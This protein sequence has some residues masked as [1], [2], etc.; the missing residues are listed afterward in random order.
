MPTLDEIVEGDQAFPLTNV[1]KLQ[2]WLPWLRMFRGF[3]IAIDYQKVLVSLL[4]VCL[5]WLGI[6]LL[7]NFLLKDSE[8]FESRIPQIFTLTVDQDFSEVWGVSV[9]S[10]R[11]LT[12]SSP[13]HS[14]QRIQ[15]EADSILW[16]FERISASFLE[17]ANYQ[18]FRIWSH[19]WLQVLWGLVVAAVF[20][21]TVSRMAARELTGHSRS[22]IRDAR[23][24]CQISLTAFLAPVIALCGLSGLWVMGWVAGLL[25]RVPVLGEILLGLCWIVI[26]VLGLLMALV[27]L[28]LM[29]GWP[30]M[31]CSTAVERNDSFDALSRSL[32][33]LLNRPWYSAFLL[34]IMWGYGT[35]VLFFVTFLTRLSLLLGLSAVSA[36]HGSEVPGSGLPSLGQLQSLGR[37]VVT[38]EVAGDMI[39]LWISVVALVPAA[40]AFSFFWTS[41][42][43]AYFLL[44]RRE[45]G[46]PLHE[47]DLSDSP[48]RSKSVL[49]IVGI[50]AAENRERERERSDDS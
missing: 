13:S 4:A 10:L 6:V 27:L 29:L 24:A 16:P 22:V 21:G 48:S 17:L 50:P 9:P 31:C 8:R 23:F 7:E 34:I 15:T 30:L 35:V 14:L 12:V 42:T 26:L 1:A 5:W 41:V 32:S 18:N 37:H 45:D 49:P 19:A 47:I 33:Y 25:G 36:G 11:S 40:F 20:G 2:R 39:E 28:G 46:T 43:I 38:S 3:R 44:R